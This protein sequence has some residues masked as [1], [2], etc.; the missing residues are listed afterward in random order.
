M[1]ITKILHKFPS[2][3]LLQNPCC[4]FFFNQKSPRLDYDPAI[5]EDLLHDKK[6][7]QFLKTLGS[8]PLEIG[9]DFHKEKKPVNVFSQSAYLSLFAADEFKEW[10]ELVKLFYRALETGNVSILEEKVERN[11]INRVEKFHRD[12]AGTNLF[13]EIPEVKEPFYK[14]H[15]NQH[16]SFQGVFIDRALNFPILNY[17]HKAT[18]NKE[19][20]ELIKEKALGRQQAVLKVK[21]NEVLDKDLDKEYLEKDRSGYTVNQYIL[22][23][24]TNMKMFLAKEEKGETRPIY[25]NLEEGFESHYIVIENKRDYFKKFPYYIVDFDF[26]LNKNPHVQG[27][28]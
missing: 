12:L 22:E 25:G 1:F 3:K 21:W 24:E 9:R 2:S 26:V 13:L 4:S 6:Y 7:F 28:Y 14:I 8:F 18:K 5:K 27:K 17:Y 19:T 15:L 11:L 10:V 23:V 16:K 20:F